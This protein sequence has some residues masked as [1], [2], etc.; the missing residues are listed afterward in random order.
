M[1]VDDVDAK[2]IQAR[3]R[4]LVSLTLVALACL[5]LTVFGFAASAVF[6]NSATKLF[7]DKNCR[8]AKARQDILRQYSILSRESPFEST[9]PKN[10]TF[11]GSNDGVSWTTLD[12]Q[13]AI[14]FKAIEN[15]IFTFRNNTADRYFRLDVTRNGGNANWLSITELEIRPMHYT[16]VD[17]ISVSYTH[18]RAHETRHDLVCRLL[19]EKKKKK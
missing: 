5:L 3:K 18:L 12:S 9:A 15:K 17:T 10:W 11:Q 1:I 16:P 6:A 8:L 13:T 19:L 2:R 14:I 4:R 7:Y